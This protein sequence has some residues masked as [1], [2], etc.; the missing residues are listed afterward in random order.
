M[1][2]S[3]DERI[4]WTVRAY[5]GDPMDTEGRNAD[6]PQPFA[7]WLA[8]RVDEDTPTGDLARDAAKA[9]DFPAVGSLRDYV[10]WVHTADL[11]KGAT[12]AL[13]NAWSA[14]LGLEEPA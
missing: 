4:E 2:M 14:H 3:L 9:D 1:T 8:L 13:L 7:A 12:A 10:T 6:E 5:V 11:P